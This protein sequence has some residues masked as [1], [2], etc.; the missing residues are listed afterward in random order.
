VGCYC[1][2]TDPYSPWQNRAEQEIREVKRL[3]GRWMVRTKS[4]RRLWDDCIELASLV[5][6][7]TAHESYKLQGQVPETIIMGQTADISHLCEFPWYAWVL[8]HESVTQF[9]EDKII[10]GKYLGPTDPGIGSVMSA[11]ILKSNGEVV[12][13]NTFRLLSPEEF[14]TDENKTLRHSYEESIIKRLGEPITSSNLPHELSISAVTP[15]YER[16][17]DDDVPAAS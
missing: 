8:F 4:P 14:D 3:A 17:E 1:K 13:R 5:L 15:Q 7:S 12:R 11:K 6:S 2:L 16:Y 10:L 9:P